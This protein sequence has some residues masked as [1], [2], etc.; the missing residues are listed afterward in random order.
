M[1]NLGTI[2]AAAG[3]AIA[4]MGV[5]SCGQDIP[6]NHVGV[7]KRVGGVVEFFDGPQWG[8]FFPP[9]SAEWDG[10]RCIDLPLKEAG[11]SADSEESQ[12]YAVAD[13]YLMIDM[14]VCYKLSKKPEDREKWWVKIQNAETEFPRSVEGV[15][16]SAANA[17]TRGEILNENHA[18]ATVPGVQKES[19][20]SA[21]PAFY[22]QVA[23][24]LRNS[25]INDRYGVDKDSY[26]VW[27]GNFSPLQKSVQADL[28][29][30]RQNIINEGHA[31]AS[32]FREKRDA[33]RAGVDAEYAKFLNDLTPMQVRYLRTLDTTG[34]I[35][36]VAKVKEQQVDVIVYQP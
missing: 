24:D 32:K 4:L 25:D 28:D 31:E 3:T 35:G 5:A 11:E 29:R 8:M 2:V 21:K 22:Q 19:A 10:R 36:T 1:R 34:A 7:R 15:A 23:L 30:Q 16:R 14:V 20:K 18:R 26:A 27:P 13:G 33:V 6:E 9:V 17:Y 12:A